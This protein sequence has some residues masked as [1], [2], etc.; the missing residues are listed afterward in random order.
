MTDKYVIKSKHGYAANCGTTV[1][2][3]LARL[4]GSKE[5]AQHRCYM[6]NYDENLWTPVKVIVT[7]VEV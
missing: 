1:D 3:N 7:V 4:Y 2:I 5:T 6:L